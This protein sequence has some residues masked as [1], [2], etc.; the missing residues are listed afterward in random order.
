[1][2]GKLGA[3]NLTA[4]TASKAGL[5]AL[6]ASLTQELRAADAPAG[7]ENVRTILV[8][9]GQ[10]STALFAG[11]TLPWYAHFLG[12]VV[13]PVELAREIVR[14][15]DEGMG[16]EISLPVYARWIEW[17]FVLPKG[18]QRGVRWVAGIDAAM[19]GV[20]ARAGEGKKDL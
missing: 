4:Y 14:M 20:G 9:P 6:H 16:G 3:A 5:I 13:E 15:V 8:A 11:T 18:L 2:L 17:V 12:P 7:S 19:A 10:L 1:M